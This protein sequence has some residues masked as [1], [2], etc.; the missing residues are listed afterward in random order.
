MTLALDKEQ[1]LKVAN[2]PFLEMPLANIGTFYAKFRVEENCLL[3]FNAVW[4]KALADYMSL[5]LFV[6]GNGTKNYGIVVEII[7]WMIGSICSYFHSDRSERTVQ[8][9]PVPRRW[10][11]PW[12]LLTGSRRGAVVL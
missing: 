1:K 6:S 7:Q 9:A 2:A 4:K 8:Q 10:V 3:D 11:R 12:I 5:H